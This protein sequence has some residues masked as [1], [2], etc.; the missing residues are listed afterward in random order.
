MASYDGDA[1]RARTVG[2]RDAGVRGSGNRRTDA[3]D[4][5]VGDSRAFQSGRLFTSP[6][7]HEGISALEPD[8]QLAFARFA[9]EKLLDLS[10]I[11]TVLT[12]LLADVNQFGACRSVFQQFGA[13]QSIVKNNLR[14]LQT[15]FALQGEQLRISRPC[16]NEVNFA[17]QG[18]RHFSLSRMDSSSPQILLL[19]LD[20]TISARRRRC[21]SSGRPA[22]LP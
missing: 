6:A 3:G 2:D 20:K 22:S 21:P 11:D 14:P 12:G 17:D 18:N 19:D 9:N 10:L 1:R 15:I 8:Y 13:H 4:D 7:E 16:P 5:F